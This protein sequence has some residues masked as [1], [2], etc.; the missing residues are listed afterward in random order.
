MKALLDIDRFRTGGGNWS[1][2]MEMDLF[3]VAAFG[4]GVKG[5]PTMAPQQSPP[6]PGGQSEKTSPSQHER[7]L[8]FSP[9]P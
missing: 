2:D 6:G 1:L 5:G 4:V 3:G 9:L 7:P 8:L